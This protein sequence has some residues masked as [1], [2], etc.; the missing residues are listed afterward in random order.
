MYIRINDELVNLD[1][2]KSIS[3]VIPFLVHPSDGQDY[4]LVLNAKDELRW[5]EISTNG[6]EQQREYSVVYGFQINRLNEKYPQNIMVGTSS[7]ADKVREEFATFLN[8]NQPIIHVI[9]F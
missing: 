7:Q 9:K 3:K 2:I 8:N 6:N 1:L 5:L 4:S